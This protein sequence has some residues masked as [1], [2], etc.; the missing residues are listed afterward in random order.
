MQRVIVIGAGLAGVEASLQL[1]KR[2]VAVTL[3][4]MKPNTKSPAHKLDTFAELVCS[5]S[6]RSDNLENACGLMK[7][8]L[9]LLDSEVIK[10][11]DRFR[12]PAGSALAVDRDRFSEYLTELLE[13]N[14]LIEI[15]N[16]EAT[17]IPE[18]EIAII[19]TGPLTSPALAEDL[20]RFTGTESLYFFDAVAPI[21][22]FASIDMQVAYFK[23]RYDKGDGLYINCP[24][25]KTE[26]DTFYQELVNAE[27]VQE[28]DFELKVFEGCMPIEE[29]A[30]RGYKTLTYGPL[31]PVGLT[32]PGADR[33]YAVVQLRQDNLAG[34]LYNLVGFQT[35]LTYAEQRRL[36]RMIPGLG[37]ANIVRYGV[38]HR[39]TFLNGPKLLHPTY[40]FKKAANLF[41][42]GQLSGVEGYVE[43]IG[44]G[45]IAGINAAKLARG[46]QTIT[47]P[48]ETT[49]GAQAHYLANADG[50]NFQPMNVNFGLLPPITTQHHK[51][52]R[53]ARFATRS[54]DSLRQLLEVNHFD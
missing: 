11:A 8:E 49:L 18:A 26:Y 24:L 37:K 35:H 38:M 43:S 6:F 22:D 33:P 45:L 28:K 25:T 40:Q 16:E 51:K 23:N 50:D 52:E 54:L 15:L 5:N 12:V 48:Q 17:A 14:P 53:R 32:K 20:R 9:R 21:V 1:A 34:T 41:A 42:A 44:S 39:N 10:A 30:R 7:A 19:A 2:N 31:K 13:I 36:I 3:Y 4:E 46:M 29:M 27:C 47:F